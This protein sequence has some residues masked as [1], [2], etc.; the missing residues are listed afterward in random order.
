MHR[1]IDSILL[2]LLS[3]G[4]CPIVDAQTFN[5]D[6]L[7]AIWENEQ[8]NDS[9]RFKAIKTVCCTNQGY[10]I[11]TPDSALHYAGLAHEYAV[12]QGQMMHASW[13][14]H[15]Q[16]VALK[17]MS[18]FRQ[19]AEILLSAIELQRSIGNKKGMVSSLNSLGNCYLQLDE[20]A[21]A[22]N[23]YQQ[24]LSI[25]RE[26]NNELEINH[27]RLNIGIIYHTI[28]EYD[29]AL[30]YFQLYYQYC[31]DESSI[32]C[33]VVAL[34]NIGNTYL[35]EKKYEEAL[36]TF[37]QGI[38]LLDENGLELRK[39]LILTRIGKVYF[40]MQDYPKALQYL[41]QATAL[42]EKGNELNFYAEALL[43]LSR[44]HHAAQLDSAAIIAEQALSLFQRISVKKGISLT[45]E[46]LADIY[47]SEGQFES[48]FEMLELYQQYQDSIYGREAQRALYRR[49]AAFIYETNKLNDQIAY[50]KQLGQQ[51]L[52]HQRQL[53]LLI[54]L[55]ALGLGSLIYQL[56]R[57]KKQSKRRQQ[58]LLS[59]INRIEEKYVN[60]AIMHRGTRQEVMLNKEKIE[61]VIRQKI[62]VT[63]WMILNTILQN[64]TISN[65]EI[66][67]EV[68]LSLEGVS[69]SLRRMYRHFEIESDTNKNKKVALIAKAIEISISEA[70]N[71]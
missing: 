12:A 7:L 44:T 21:T 35:N 6:S 48:A 50:E 41:Q 49:E 38:A 63:S 20:L 26:R 29:Q 8:L 2:L 10:Q 58:E 61:R 32:Y 14:L 24:G 65:K 71:S 1:R 30:E 70:P 17:N 3:I 59:T 22:L 57:R 34:V 51:Q 15:H 11:S 5:P 37:F 4:I 19:A 56:K 9:L 25:A 42:L 67:Q 16:G 18:Q 36:S 27:L 53:F 68:N 47:K 66:A 39:G 33:Q 52:K 45:A 40:D 31:I 54:M 69:S 64:P 46:L 62:G 60:K 28:E 13:F 23:Y 55:A 43:N